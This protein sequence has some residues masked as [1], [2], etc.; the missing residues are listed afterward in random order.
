MAN[1]STAAQHTGDGFLIG[2][3]SVLTDIF[4]PVRLFNFS[5]VAQT[6]HTTQLQ[7]IAASED[8]IDFFGIEYSTDQ[9]AWQSIG[10]VQAGRRQQ[11]PAELWLYSYQTGF[12]E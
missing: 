6:N 1:W 5:A 7:W 8:N 11:Y 4:L 12:R 3:S 2:V 10:A 9:T